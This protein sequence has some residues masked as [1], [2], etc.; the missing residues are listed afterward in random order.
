LDNTERSRRF[1]LRAMAGTLGITSL[2]LHWPVVA[3]AAHHAQQA[4]A[5]SGEARI[6]FLTSAERKDVEAISAQIIPSDGTPGAREAGVIFFIDRALATF[7]SSI[8]KDF[9]AGLAAFQSACHARHP[10]CESFAAL[11]SA[12]Q[13]EFLH[14]V[15]GTPFFVRVRLLTVLGMFASP[16]HGGNRNGVGW[17]LIG[18]EDRHMFEPPFGFYDRDYPGFK[19]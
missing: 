15:E 16:A 6:T 7:F 11:P 14:E 12:Q 3:N 1:F 18:F 2:E 9:R 13:I 17:K 4:A 8:A 19:A 5:A 10:D